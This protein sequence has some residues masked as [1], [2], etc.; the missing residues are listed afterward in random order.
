MESKCGIIPPAMKNAFFRHAIFV[1]FL[2]PSLSAAQGP[3]AGGLKT[4]YLDDFAETC[5]HL[6]Q[7][8]KAMPGN[9]YSWRPGPGVRSVSEVYVHIANGNFLLLSLTG[10][11]LPTEYF[12]NLTT[13]AKGKPDTKASKALF[14]RMGELEKTVAEKDAVM[15]MLKSSLDAVRN[16]FSKLT[17]TELDQPADFFGQ[18]TTVRRIYLRI[19]AHVNEHYGQSVA[20]A[21]V[22]GI[23]PPWSQ[24]QKPE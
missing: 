7:L 12:P 23:V 19:L 1:L 17:P 9:K 3:N 16:R 22:N 14:K 18:R 24:T 11:K 2:A 10:V 4:E 20:Y 21:R 5:K 13:D 6:D 8:S 15:R